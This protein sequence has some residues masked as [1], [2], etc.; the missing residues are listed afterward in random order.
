[1]HISVYLLNSRFF[2]LNEDP[3][4]CI[5]CHSN[6]YAAFVIQGGK[7]LNETKLLGPEDTAW[8]SP[9]GP[10]ALLPAGRESEQAVFRPPL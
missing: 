5:N 1:M 10:G 6:S 2:L 9:R 7:G 3:N 4:L 8:C